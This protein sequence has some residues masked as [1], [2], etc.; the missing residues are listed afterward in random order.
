MPLMQMPLMNVFPYRSDRGFSK[1]V[2]DGTQD[3]FRAGA[4]P[5]KGFDDA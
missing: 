5:P 4:V 3:L 1:A 2:T